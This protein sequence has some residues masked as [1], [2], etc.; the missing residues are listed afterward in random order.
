MQEL[1]DG[2]CVALPTDTV[3]GLAAS[4]DLPDAVGMLFE[5]KRRPERVPIAVL[6]ADE[7][8][9]ST[10]AVITG[11][12]RALISRSWP[13][14]LTLVLEARSGVDAVVGSDDGS[15][16]VRCPDHPFVRAVAARVGPLATTS[17]NL[18][19]MATPVDAEGVQR[20]FGDGLVV[21]DGGICDRSPSTVLD[22]RG[23]EPVLL[24]R[25]DAIV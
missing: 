18:H 16:G 15:V 17:A 1:R 8:Q 7:E 23:P 2:H 24:R 19:G 9:T 5:L 22:A 10:V 4:L 6:V 12:A 25:G 14:P 20:L 11:K 3:Y 13:G 21:L